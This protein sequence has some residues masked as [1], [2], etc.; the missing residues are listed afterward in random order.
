[1]LKIHILNVANGDSIVIEYQDLNGIRHFGVCDSNLKKITDEVPAIKK[2]ESLG[3]KGHLSFVALTHPHMD[4]YLGLAQI[5]DQYTVKTFFSFPLDITENKRLKA[6]AA[7]AVKPTKTDNS[8]ISKSA[9]ELVKLIYAGK[10][11]AG[12]WIDLT[13]HGQKLF[14]DGFAGID[15]QAVQPLKSNKAAFFEMLDNGDLSVLSS[16]KAN[17]V[18]LAI[19]I[20]CYGRRII[21]GGDSTSKNWRESERQLNRSGVTNLNVEILKIPHHGSRADNPPK[22]LDYVYTNKKTEKIGL[23]SAIGDEHHPDGSVLKYF[24][25]NGILPYCTN[26]ARE[27]STK[28]VP[29]TRL[30]NLVP[31][32]SDF[33]NESAIRG[34]IQTAPCQGDICV[35]IF[36][37]GSID[38]DTELNNFC[39]YRA[40]TS[41]GL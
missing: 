4:H 38:V 3:A 6:L 29:Q 27:C 20:D 35:T 21:L 13:G 41:L 34:N 26:L 25:E 12:E 1:M 14:A 7:L 11:R 22:V 31:E 39:P 33:I 9:L 28:I 37:D 5:F 16:Q 40:S 10:H 23:I 18:S 15:M 17:D 36:P 24:G 8:Q 30:D 2:L 32:L 19:Q